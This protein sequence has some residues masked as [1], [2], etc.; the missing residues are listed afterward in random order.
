[1]TNQSITDADKEYCKQ[2]ILIRV[3]HYFHA[4]V[5]TS[6]SVDLE[7]VGEALFAIAAHHDEGLNDQIDGLGARLLFAHNRLNYISDYIG[8]RIHF[9]EHRKEDEHL[10]TLYDEFLTAQKVTTQEELDKAIEEEPFTTKEEYEKD[11]KGLVED[12]VVE[13]RDFSSIYKAALEVAFLC[14][15]I[16]GYEDFFRYHAI[17]IVNKEHVDQLIQIQS[18]ALDGIDK[19]YE[20]DRKKREI[21]GTDDHRVSTSTH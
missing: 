13:G 14:F 2:E 19:I 18:E 8:K 7:G 12:L 11:L 15:R 3:F 20:D 21:L 17:C 5:G 4:A 16:A 9:A 10:N 1:M 6:I